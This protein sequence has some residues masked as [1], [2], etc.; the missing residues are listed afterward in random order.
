MLSFIETTNFKKLGDFR[1]DFTEGT[2]LVLGD[3]GMGKTTIFNAVRFALFG[4]AA[5]ASSSENIPTWGE[6]SCS[7]KAGFTND[8]LIVRTLRDCKIF[9]AASDGSL[10]EE[11][12]LKVAEGTT[13]CT[14]WVME[15][16]GIDHKMFSIF[17]MSM[18]GETG[19]LITLGATELNR[20]VEN[21]SGVGVLDKV[22]KS[23][24][25]SQSQLEGALGVVEYVDITDRE[26][27]YKKLGECVEKAVS[28]VEFEKS[29]VA[30]VH[31]RRVLA[32]KEYRKAVTHNQTVAA[33]LQEQASAQTRVDTLEPRVSE[34]K[35][36]VDNLTTKVG[37]YEFESLETQIAEI[38]KQVSS[39]NKDSVLHSSYESQLKQLSTEYDLYVKNSEK[40][41]EV[42]TQRLSLETRIEST[43]TDLTDLGNNTFAAINE[44]VKAQSS[45]EGGS[46]GE[47]HRPFE[48]FDP[49]AAQSL[50]DLKS[51]DVSRCQELQRNCKATLADLKAKLKALPNVGEG[52]AEKATAIAVRIEK[53]QTDITLVETRWEN[54]EEDE[55][56]T[57]RNE[58]ANKLQEGRKWRSQLHSDTK[59]LASAQENLKVASILL[60]DVEVGEP[61]PTVLLE[62][63]LEQLAVQ[64]TKQRQD[65]ESCTTELNTLKSEFAIMGNE[66][67][68][69]RRSNEKFAEY[70]G[71]IDKTKRLTKFLRDSRSKYMEGVW[72]LILGA[73]TGWINDTTNGWI[74]AVGRNS[75]T[76]DFTFTENGIVAPAK[77]EASGA[78]KEFIGTSLRIGLGMALQGSRSMILLD[79]PTAG[80][81]EEN[82]DKLATGLLGVSGQKIIITHRQSERLTAANVVNV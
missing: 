28:A 48:D 19:A 66:L 4:T 38:E 50:F 33:Q 60:A 29:V 72:S 18:Q 55:Q 41:S 25:K 80:M 13:P 68:G 3:N 67:E 7:V 46:C 64:L 5:I 81:R 1:A 52:N 35:Q 79:E 69:Y 20:I 21:F 58:L 17:N 47:C 24:S 73:A 70:S 32:D 14:K 59:S 40:E 31:D 11:D 76:G 16:L 53:L 9:K 6:K 15:H 78:Q 62:A 61:L 51:N 77:S 44:R 30:E 42:A 82:A 71:D 37:G 49:E 57:L 34:L 27:D 10:I 39:F 45:L 8:F 65:L 2:N 36:T 63:E 22:I 75:K 56:L 12:S 74:T 54:F 26:G 23:L 43:S